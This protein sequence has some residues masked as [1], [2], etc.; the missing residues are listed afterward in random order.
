[1]QHQP[2]IV[3]WSMPVTI[4]VLFVL[5]FSPIRWIG[6]ANWFSAQARVVISPI[7]H[8]I[9]IAVDTIIPPPIADPAATERERAMINELDRVR[10]EL[11]QIREENKQLS[12]LVEQ[13]SRGASITPNLEVRQIR[14]PRIS[15]LVG[16][17]LSVRTGNIDGLVQGTV[18]VVDAVQL[19]GK[20]SRV[21]AR[22]STVLPIT[23]KSAPP[24]LATIL[25][26]TTGTERASCLLT[27]LGDG[28]LRGEVGRAAA[29]QEWQIRV[30]QEVRLLD[31]QWPQH[32][33]MLIIGTVERIERNE[34]QPL[35]QRIIVRPNITDLRR[36]PEVILRLPVLDESSSIQSSDGG[37]P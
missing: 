25:L 26:N 9:T 5:A 11:L 28:T 35:R 20:V 8:P 33:Q 29:D 15:G 13:F 4:L 18:V 34:V 1:M 6:W 14:C 31:N 12:Q 37:N 36:V 2:M 23:A 10:T 24:I 19:L 27:P 30:G 7:A 21:D 22:S 16:D 3:R 32:A 17:F